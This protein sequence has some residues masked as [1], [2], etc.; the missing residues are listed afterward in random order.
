MNPARLGADRQM[1]VCMQCHLQTTSSR[2][3]AAIRRFDRGPFSYRAGERLSDFTLFF[4][5]APGGGHAEKFE[6]VSSVTRLRESQCYLQSK[7]ALTCLTCHDPHSVPRREA[8]APHYSAACRQ[9]HSAAFNAMVASAKHTAD[10]DCVSCHMP[11]RRTDDVVHAVITD[12]LI[13]RRK[14]SRDLLAGIPEVH[15]P[16]ATAYRGEV[17]PYYPKTLSAGADVLYLAVAQVQHGSNLDLGIRQLTNEIEKQKP[18]NAEFYF[19]LG[20][21][22]RQKGDAAKAVSAYEQAVI[23]N[24]QS[25]W[26]LRR[27]ADG[28]EALGQWPRAADALNRAIQA[29]PDDA[30]SWY[31]MGEVY[32]HSGTREEEIRAYR[33]SAELDPE[34]SDA[35]NNL[36]SALAEKGSLEDAETAFRAALR[37]QS[38][39]ADAQSNLGML[40]ASKGQLAE[41]ADH[42]ARALESKPDNAAARVAFALALARLNRAPEAMHQVQLALETDPKLPNAHL[43]LGNLLQNAQELDRAIAE[44]R[45]A[46]RL[47]PNLGRAQV[48]L[49]TALAQKGDVN[50][51]VEQL[52]RAA[53]GAD[54]VVRARALA[55]LKAIGK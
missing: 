21:A 17:V 9:C 46:L 34:L 45:E 42:F 6:I 12:H 43:L 44:Y 26:T 25:A 29:A 27:M 37:V 10:A 55:V 3:P 40:L 1:E 16:D 31:A 53:S 2:L 7:G 19:N 24:P 51:A 22:W 39:F 23:R 54:P 8:A 50:G 28:L 14:P 32:A 13:Q 20:E 30:R 11:K 4:D 33:K 48:D 35:Y 41:A 49:G 52:R 5:R 18:G 47:S 38:D 15:E 36:G